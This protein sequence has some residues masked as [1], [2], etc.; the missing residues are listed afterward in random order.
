MNRSLAA[1]ALLAASLL[2]ASCGQALAQGK[3]PAGPQDAD[4]QAWW[5]FTGELSSDAMEGRDTGSTAYENSAVL[6][7]SRLKAAGLK[8]LGTDGW[9]QPVVV[10]ELAVTKAS[11]RMGRTRLRFLA[12]FTVTPRRGMPA[13]LSAPLAYRGYCGPADLGDVA[14]RLVICHGTR[15]SGLPTPAER[16]AAVRKA[17]ATGLIEIADPG[18]TVEPPRWPYAYARS[19]ALA[20]QL[21]PADSFIKL[22]LRAE[23]LGSLI[24]GGAQLVAAGAAG[25]PLPPRDAKLPLQLTFA[26]AERRVTSSNVVGSLPGTDPALADQAIVLTAH[27]DGYGHGYPVKGDDLYNGT[28]DDAAYVALIVRLLER[29]QG[30]GFARPVIALLVTGEEKGLLGSKY[31]VA[32]PTWPLKRV[33]A[34]INLDQLRPIF[35]LRRLTVHART[36]STLGDDVEAVARSMG[37]VTQDDPEPERNLLRRTDHWNFILAGIPA[38]N[39]VLGYDPGSPSEAVYRQWY[40]TGYHRPQDDMKQAIDWQAAADFNRFFYALVER[41]ANQPQAP[42]WKPGSALKPKP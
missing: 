24:P 37:I 15:K 32:N 16:E 3:S 6:V 23:V 11:A 20:G 29:Q 42:A 2:A 7:A 25:Q 31:W 41:V 34:N 36:D 13:Q 12:D 4:T 28:L 21:P 27:L 38:T 39:F 30:K 35:P 9:I 22:T 40:R 1:R 8:P 14:G 33:A 5:A 17:G 19:F 18:F 10:D 26:R